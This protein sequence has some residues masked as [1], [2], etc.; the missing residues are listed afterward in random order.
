MGGASTWACLLC[1]RDGNKGQEPTTL[2]SSDP[3]GRWLVLITSKKRF[4]RNATRREQGRSAGRT[5]KGRCQ[6]CAPVQ[7]SGGRLVLITP[8]EGFARNATRREQRAGEQ[9]VGMRR[10]APE[11]WIAM[12]SV[13]G[14]HI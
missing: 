8:E 9:K 5:L 14:S 2:Q 10:G 6:A 3:A 11:V 12:G 13:M 1:A 7:R 4:A